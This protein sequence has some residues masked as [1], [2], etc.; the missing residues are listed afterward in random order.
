M[1]M[2]P[3]DQV[4]IIVDTN[5]AEDRV[6]EALGGLGVSV[7]RAQLPVGDAQ[8]AAP[9][10]TTL[11]FERKRERDWAA[12]ILDGRL[13]AQ[14]HRLALAATEAPTER[15]VH[16][17]FVFEGTLPR[18]S[19]A[20]VA[21]KLQARAVAGS[22]ARTAVLDHV[23]VIVTRDADETAHMLRAMLKSVHDPKTKA[24]RHTAAS[25]G[26]GVLGK[27]PRELKDEA[28]VVALLS[29]VPGV[30]VAAA[31][32]LG[33]LYPT[34][35]TLLAVDEATLAEAQVHAQRRLGKALARKLKAYFA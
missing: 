32:V 29:A 21:P 22:V 16:T 14:K 34:V 1:I 12:S 28:P 6:A 19:D 7:Q 18:W 27:R 13:R 33:A 2:N 4:R 3:C 8:I 10:G 9:D 24:Q 11:V 15:P 20:P 23:P 26:A 31:Q 17:F 30:S 5:S 35:S 25:T